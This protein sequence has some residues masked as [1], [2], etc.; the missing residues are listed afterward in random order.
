VHLGNSEEKNTYIHT[1]PGNSHKPI[2]Q[3]ALFYICTQPTQYP[4]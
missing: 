1:W 4:L 3:N 2:K